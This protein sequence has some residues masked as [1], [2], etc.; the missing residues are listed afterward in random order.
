MLQEVDGE[1]VLL[2]LRSESYFGLDGVGT[3][4]WRPVED[5]GRLKVV[6]A[7]LLDEYDVEPVRLENDLKELIGRLAGAGLANV[8]SV[9]AEEA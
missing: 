8:E 5:D 6:Q 9:G 3:R 2:D 4:I 1:A 7:K